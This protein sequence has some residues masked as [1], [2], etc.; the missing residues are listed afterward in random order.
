MSRLGTVGLCVIALAV[1]VARTK[2]DEPD[3]AKGHAV[4]VMKAAHVPIDVESQEG[5]TARAKIM[6]ALDEETKF[7]FNELPLQDV[8]AY[9]KDRHSIEIQLDTRSLENASIGV[10]SPVTRQLDHVSLRAALQLTLGAMDLTYLIK[11]EVLL[12]T[13]PEIASRETMVRIYP[14]ADLITLDPKIK[15]GQDV[16]ALIEVIKGTLGNSR[17]QGGGGNGSIRAWANGQVLV[18][19]QTWAGHE[20]IEPLLAGL[21]ESRSVEAQRVHDKG[22]VDWTEATARK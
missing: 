2:G 8:I 3:E 4:A 14:V 21:R 1:F 18:I 13:T 5:A 7:E 9:L 22:I 19:R 17:W 16:A 12:I 6:R 15:Q 11:D 20:E 10:E